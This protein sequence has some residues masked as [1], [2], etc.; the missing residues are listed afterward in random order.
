MTPFKLY[1]ELETLYDK[2]FYYFIYKINDRIR[3]IQASSGSFGK[4][5]LV[6]IPPASYKRLEE[7]RSVPKNVA[8][9]F[10]NAIFKGR[11]D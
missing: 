4:W 3:A 2:D 9:R 11:L 10:F 5:K 8:Y 1:K 7:V 6:N